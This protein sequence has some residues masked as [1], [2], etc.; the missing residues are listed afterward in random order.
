MVLVRNG[1]VLLVG[2]ESG[3]FLMPG[4]GIEPGELPMAAAVRELHE[5]TGLTATQA[6]FWFV[7]ES[8]TNRHHVFQVEADGKVEIG[9]EISE[10]RWLHPTERVPSHSHVEVI[11]ARLD[12]LS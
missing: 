1:R 2:D 7:W 9:P 11:R 8:A 6:Q 12:D 4:G 3:M 10:F 5:E